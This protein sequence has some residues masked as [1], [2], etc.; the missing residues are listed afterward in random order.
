MN[1][2]AITLISVVLGGGILGAVVAAY[3]AIAER[4]KTEVEAEAVG[5]KTPG[6]VE[7]VSVATMVSALNA[8]RAINDDL[9]QDNELLRQEFRNLNTRFENS[10]QIRAEDSRNLHDDL[11]G[12]RKALQAAQDYIEAW[13][14]WGQRVAPN[15][16]QPKA[17]PGY[18]RI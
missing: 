11:T 6:E 7:S 9:R 1:E 12:L 5:A 18:R 16:P 17:P 13:I 8:A 15:E 10:E 3:K 2:T 14:A 4:R